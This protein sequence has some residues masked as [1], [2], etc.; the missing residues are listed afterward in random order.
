MKKD[1]QCLVLDSSYMPR[2]VI[3][4]ERAFCIHFKGNCEIVHNHPTYFKTVNKNIAYPKPSIIRVFS[5]IKMQYNRVPLS[6][7][8]IYK[9]DGYRCVYC[10]SESRSSFTLD[11]VV[12][13]SKGGK[14]SWDNLVTACEKCNGE[15]ANLTIEEW[16]RE[17]PRPKRPH[18]LML[19]KRVRHIP[20]E[21]KP[22]IFY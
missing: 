20:E 2:S 16:G 12:P 10:G 3:T 8:N 7:N 19:L 1:T 18:F 4:T 15:K 6:R 21:W 14:D 22:Y 11:H 13:K 9:R 17:H 5:Y